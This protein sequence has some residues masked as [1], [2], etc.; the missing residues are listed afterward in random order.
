MGFRD[1]LRWHCPLIF[2]WGGIADYGLAFPKRS[3]GHTCGVKWRS[4]RWNM[5]EVSWCTSDNEMK[6]LLDFFPFNDIISRSDFQ[7]MWLE[8]LSLLAS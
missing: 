5:A 4:E 1:F 8:S 3:R 2:K 6:P 7:I